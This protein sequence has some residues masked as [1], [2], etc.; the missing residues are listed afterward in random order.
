M[1]PH[2]AHPRQVVFELRQLDLELAL[3]GDGVL[4]EDVEDQLGAIDDAGLE[5]ILERALLNRRDLVVDDQD[6][7]PGG[8]KGALEL[9]QLA[10]AD[11]GARVGL[12]AVL[13]DFRGD[14]DAGGARQLAQL[15]QLAGHVDTVRKDREREAALWFCTRSGIGLARGHAT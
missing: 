6:V 11:E 10:L 9:R 15:G 3:G 4:G 5:R 2:A 7:G 1:L 13:N 8:G 14:L 12:G